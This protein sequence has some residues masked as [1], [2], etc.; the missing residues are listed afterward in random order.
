M[1]FQKSA[2]MT[3]EQFPYWE[4]CYVQLWLRDPSGKGQ[5]QFSATCL[6][7]NCCMCDIKWA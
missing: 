4:H 2:K 6:T 3:S 7:V 5:G 1:Y